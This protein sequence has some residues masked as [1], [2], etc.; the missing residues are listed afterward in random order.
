MLKKENKKLKKKANISLNDMIEL[1]KTKWLTLYESLLK[2]MVD[3]IE[4]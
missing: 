4:I 2:K 1:S 3:P